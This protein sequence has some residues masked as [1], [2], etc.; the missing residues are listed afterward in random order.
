MPF[1]NESGTERD[2]SCFCHVI[3]A[4]GGDPV[5][6]VRLFRIVPDA[7][8]ASM[9]NHDGQATGDLGA[10]NPHININFTYHCVL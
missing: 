1:A 9:Q 6:G 8:S 10:T 2:T 4:N 5:Q 3:R 7:S